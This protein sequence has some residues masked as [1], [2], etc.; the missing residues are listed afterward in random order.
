MLGVEYQWTQQLMTYAQWST[1]F[2]GGGVNP[3]PFIPQQ[4]VPFGTENLRATEI[5]LKSDLFDNHLRLNVA[6]F[7]NQYNNILFDEYRARPSSTA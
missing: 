4:E 2:R 5:G 1:G 6:G 3:R 7:F